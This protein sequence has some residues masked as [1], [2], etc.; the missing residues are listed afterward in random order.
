MMP[1]LCTLIPWDVNIDQL[2][3][4]LLCAD[5]RKGRERARKFRGEIATREGL[6]VTLRH[7]SLSIRWTLNEEFGDLR[8]ENVCHTSIGHDG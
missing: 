8:G 1:E 6:P 4:W 2:W 7:L 5:S 3:K